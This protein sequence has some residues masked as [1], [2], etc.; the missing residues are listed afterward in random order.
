MTPVELRNGKRGWGAARPNYTCP[1]EGMV[2]G[3]RRMAVGHQLEDW[4]LPQDVMVVLVFVAARYLKDPLPN[5]RGKRVTPLP[6][7][8]LR[9]A[10]GDSFAQAQLL[11]HLLKPQK[12][13]VGGEA[14]PVEGGF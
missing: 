8:P 1:W 11:V 9:H 10:L 2:T 7:S 13:A 6:P 14:P 4:V 5:E 3:S 12:A